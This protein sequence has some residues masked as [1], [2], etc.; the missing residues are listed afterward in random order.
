MG[1]TSPTRRSVLATTGTLFASAF[2]PRVSLAAPG[3]DPRFLFVFLRG[4][5]DG[6]AMVAPV[7]DPNYEAARGGLELTR[8]GEK[9]GIPLDA[10]FVLNPKMPFLASL[11][12]NR[13]AAIIHAVASPY[14]ERSHFDGQDVVETG[15]GGVGR[16]DT[17]WMN[18]MI[19]ALGSTDRVATR[20]GLAIGA[21]LPIVMRGPKP[22]VTWLPPG[23]P[24]TK[25]E[26]RARVL[27]LYREVD[28]GLAA[29]Y[30]TALEL[31]RAMGGE[32][33]VAMAVA[34]A[35]KA[36][37]P[38]GNPAFRS[39][40]LSAGN[41]MSRDD[42]PRVATMSFVGWDTHADEGPIV[43][44]LGKLS[45]SLDATLEGLAHSMAPVW[46]DTV[47]VVATEFGRTVRM[48]GT[49]GTDHGTASI[50]LVVG[51]GVRGGRVITDWPGLAEAQL[52]QK[53]DLAPTTDLRAVLKGV[54]RDHLGLGERV[55]SEIIFP[56]S[57]EVRS[58]P[59][60]VA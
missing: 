12:R 37:P 60:L 19:G 35:M 39:A 30:E 22:V 48:N 3:R 29:R 50:A 8:T 58:L 23:Y 47:I 21:S 49:S 53:R 32:A 28:P 36:E 11:F 59:D 13:E 20:D 52:H 43:G 57:G 34:Q 4:G 31:S 18:R 2:I 1:R 7:G 9:A 44:A 16:V 25:E 5:L 41:L 33:A 46:R 26:L 24:A 10:D 42:G 40:A 17:G 56:G 54:A 14:R 45:E 6:L 55:L 27:D 38:R 15:L 51:G